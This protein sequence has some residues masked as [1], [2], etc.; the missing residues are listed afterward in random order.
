MLQACKHCTTRKYYTKKYS[1]HMKYSEDKN[2]TRGH[3]LFSW[4]IANLTENL[5]KYYR[6]RK[7]KEKENKKKVR[8]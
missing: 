5:I 4:R 3:G 6:E 8:I 7:E 1:D 2:Y